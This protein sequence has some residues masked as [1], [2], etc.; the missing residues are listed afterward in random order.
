MQK[1][2]K[3]TLGDVTIR[4]PVQTHQIGAILLYA[5][6]PGEEGKKCSACVSHAGSGP[7]YECI[8]GTTSH[9]KGACLNCFFTGAMARCE[10]YKGKHSTWRSRWQAHVAGQADVA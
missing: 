10:L 5:L 2:V 6:Q 7:F 4:N 8:R 3:G 1:V 9:T